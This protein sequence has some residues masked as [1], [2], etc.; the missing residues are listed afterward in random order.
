[1]AVVRPGTD[2]Y[3]PYLKIFYNNLNFNHNT[4]LFNGVHI[5][6]KTMSILLN[7]FLTGHATNFTYS[8]KT[9]ING[10]VKFGWSIT[11]LSD[12]YLFI[13]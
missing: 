1:M 7:P 10:W 3:Q 12:N 8:K 11:F 6:T 9:T 5:Y 13:K 2:R 4:E